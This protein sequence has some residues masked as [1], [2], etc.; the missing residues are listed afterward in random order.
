MFFRQSPNENIFVLGKETMRSE[1]EV[2]RLQAALLKKKI[3]KQIFR[4]LARCDFLAKIKTF[5]SL[6]IQKNSF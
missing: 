4:L 6:E 2:E 3:L 5:C 1:Q